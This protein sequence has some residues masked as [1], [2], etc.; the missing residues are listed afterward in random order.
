MKFQ[1]QWRKLKAYA[2]KK[3]IRII[4]DLPIYVA[5]DSA[6]SWFHPELF[7]FDD[8]RLPKGVAGC[9]PDGFCATGQLWGNP[10]YDWK[11][12]KATGYQWW[13]KRIAY[14]F[15]LYD[16]VRVDH[17]RGFDEYYSVP[18]GEETAVN[19][20]WEK[21]PGLDF[22]KAVKKRF[23]DLDIIAEVLGFLT[24]SV[25]KLVEDTGFP[26]MKV[27]EFAFYADGQSAYLPYRY[28]EN[29]VVYT[30]THDN[31]TLKSWYEDMEPWDRDF[32]VRYLGNENT[33][34][35]DIHWD[36]IRLA[37]A[38]VAKLAVIPLQD[39]LG[40]GGE[41]RMNTPSTLGLNWKW[42][43]LPDE[44]SKELAAKCRDM[45]WV[46]GRCR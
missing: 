14:S 22:F 1:E 28:K 13:M 33:K 44:F 39:Y 46:F 25:L 40:L 8:L 21:G 34:L 9:P 36:F 30:G 38:S 7:Q 3:G 18:Y 37:M 26:G 10:L 15:T 23:G 31:D 20:K 5:F 17:F 42:R 19:G 2:N 6:D 27:L 24:P 29:C 45:A 35:Q 32:A 41:A 4:G 16:C 11:Y 43:L 12:H